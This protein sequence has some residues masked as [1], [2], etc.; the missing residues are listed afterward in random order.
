VEKIYICKN[1]CILYRWAEY[2]DLEK[3][4]FVDSTDSIIKK[5]AVVM[6]THIT[7]ARK[8]VVAYF[9]KAISHYK[10]KEM[11]VIPFNIGNHWVLLS[12]SIMY[13]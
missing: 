5:M 7:L 8:D 9:V 13:D 10:D 11:L 3:C 12:I 1:D 4:L 2:E 6:R